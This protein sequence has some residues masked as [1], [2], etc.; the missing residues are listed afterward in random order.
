MPAFAE[1]NLPIL[2]AEE[3]K[4]EIEDKVAELSVRM[5]E[6]LEVVDT[7]DEKVVEVN[8]ETKSLDPA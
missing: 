6:S 5:K 8:D 2:L 7:E 1:L 4:V 3:D